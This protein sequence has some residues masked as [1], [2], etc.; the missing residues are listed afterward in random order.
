MLLL[1]A[2]NLVTSKCDF[3]QFIETEIVRH[4][5]SPQANL[6]NFKAKHIKYID[7]TG[8]RKIVEAP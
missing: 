1:L 2:L 8:L 5:P 7:L 4:P 6:I 3:C